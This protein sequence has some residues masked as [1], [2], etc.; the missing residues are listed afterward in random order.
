[1]RND[2][3]LVYQLLQ[4]PCIN[5]DMSLKVT[6]ISCMVL[7][8]HVYSLGDCYISTYSIVVHNILPDT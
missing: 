2:D 1:M 6:W 8:G 7:Y 4:Y 5:L 3:I